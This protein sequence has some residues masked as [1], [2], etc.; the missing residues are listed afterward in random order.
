MLSLSLNVRLFLIILSFLPFITFA[1][2]ATVNRAGLQVGMNRMDFQL[3]AVYKYEKHSIKPFAAIEFGINRTIFQKRF[4]PRF[5][6]GA[7]Y[8]LIKSSAFQFGPQIVYSYA[9]LKVNKNTNHFYQFNELYGGLYFCYGQKVQVKMA[10][11]TGWQNER[12]YST[13]LG[14]HE[15]ANSLG[16]SINC[17][18]NYAF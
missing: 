2:H 5:S 16:F 3:G 1:Q 15:G 7:D 4:F 8:S 18:V 10:L 13:Y 9:L 11:L 17:G 6:V 12:F 14:K